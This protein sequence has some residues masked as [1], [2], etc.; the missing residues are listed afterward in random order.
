ME[1][2]RTLRFVERPDAA[3]TTATTKL[4]AISVETSTY[5]AAMSDKQFQHLNDPLG[6]R[7]VSNGVMTVLERLFARGK[8]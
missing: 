5:I 6:G 2:L 1:G 8:R 7:F 3:P 4:A